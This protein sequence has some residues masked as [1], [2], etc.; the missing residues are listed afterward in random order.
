[1]SGQRPS[2]S[3]GHWV[4]TL[5]ACLFLPYSLTSCL[6][7]CARQVRDSKMDH[8]P[9]HQGASELT[10]VN[11]AGVQ[12]ILKQEVGAVEVPRGLKRRQ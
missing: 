10:G 11:K 5:P 9:C 2:V 12:I 4:G 1:M 7:L 8:R 6:M 3:Y